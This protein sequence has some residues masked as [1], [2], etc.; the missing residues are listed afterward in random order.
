[1]TN[2]ELAAIEERA[3]RTPNSVRLAGPWVALA[4]IPPLVAE[5]RRLRALVEAAYA[6]GYATAV[7]HEGDSWHHE[8]TGWM[9][10]SAHDE[11]EGTA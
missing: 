4:D 1:M 3:T 6:E 9:Q 2:D 5:V 10:S 8:D 7:Q 11:L